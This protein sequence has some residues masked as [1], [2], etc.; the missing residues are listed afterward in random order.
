[1]RQIISR[2]ARALLP[3]SLALCA[4][5]LPGGTERA[6]MFM[7]ALLTARG[8]SLCAGGALRAAAGAVVRASRLRG[9]L[10]TAA[11]M[12]AFGGIAAIALC[13]TDIPYFRDI[14]IFTAVSGAFVNMSQVFA[15][16]MYASEDRPSAI[17]YDIITAALAAVGL[18]ISAADKWLMPVLTGAGML[19]G[20]LLLAGLK[21]SSS[22]QKGFRV[23]RYAPAALLRGWVA[24]AVIAAW[25]LVSAESETDIAALLLGIAILEWC[26]PVFRRSRDESAACSVALGGIP[27]IW[28][29]F[30]TAAALFEGNMPEWYSRAPIITTVLVEAIPAACALAMAFGVA[31]DVLHI[32][33][34]VMQVLSLAALESGMFGL[35][36]GMIG[37]YIA[38][39]LCVAAVLL[40]IPDMAA[41]RRA[42]R[43][44]RIQKKRRR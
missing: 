24:P 11:A 26:E 39:G 6:L 28:L 42:A 2:P 17:V 3:V 1:M 31:A 40:T 15:D 25:A 36:P 10:I 27:A 44:R 43:A 37:M 7:A 18:I 16:R 4:A 21:N 38:L 20:I 5:L 23:F 12:A 41:L 33:V 14:G 29:I 32:S 13:L 34:A 8:L 22:V 30:C 9:N 19:A 35:E